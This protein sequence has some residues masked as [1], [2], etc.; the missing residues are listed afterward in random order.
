MPDPYKNIDAGWK[1]KL[2]DSFNKNTFDWD[3]NPSE[4]QYGIFNR[5][6]EDGKM[7]WKAESK[8]QDGLSSWQYPAG[9]YTT[10]FIVTVQ[11]LLISSNPKNACP[12]INFRNNGSDF[13]EFLVCNNGFYSVLLYTEQNGWEILISSSWNTAIMNN[14]YNWL[15]VSAHGNKFQFFINGQLVDHLADSTLD[16]GN[17]GVIIDQSGKQSATYEFD[18]LL[19]LVPDVY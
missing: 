19:I 10:D 12:G 7:I 14:S 17:I 13:Y 6:I 8:S 5:V 18:N 1:V 15:T 3:A 11:S 9:S 16:R 2:C 4:D